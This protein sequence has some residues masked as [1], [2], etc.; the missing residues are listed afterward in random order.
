MEIEIGT[1]LKFSVCNVG[2]QR[3]SKSSPEKRE[4]RST[5]ESDMNGINSS[6]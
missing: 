5:M 1:A 6:T 3:G 4:A 2:V